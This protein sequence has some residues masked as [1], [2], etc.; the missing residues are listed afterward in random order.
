MAAGFLLNFNASD[1]T[2]LE[3]YSKPAIQ[4]H[5]DFR[6]S[7]SSANPQQ[8]LPTGEIRA[9]LQNVALALDA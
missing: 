8:V 4:S 1:G 6:S 2:P 7:S 3:D 9:I 5:N